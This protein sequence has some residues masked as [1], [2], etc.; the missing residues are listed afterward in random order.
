[1]IDSRRQQELQKLLERLGVERQTAINWQLLDQALIHPTFSST[2][3][4]DQLEFLGDS[5]L[6]LA[7]TLFLRQNFSNYAVGQLA[8]LRSHLVSD[9]VLAEIADGYGLDRFLMMKAFARRD[10][11][12]V[13]SRLADALEA[14]LAALYLSSNDLSLIT[15]WLN[16][17]LTQIST[18]LVADPTLGNYKAALQEFTQLHWKLLPEYRT[19]EQLEQTEPT[20][21]AEVWLLGQLWGQGQGLSIKAAQQSAAAVALQTLTAEVETLK[22]KTL[23]DQST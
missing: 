12:A 17:H 6:R 15:P 18:D 20:F 22:I 5:V 1:M 23:N 9:R 16:A 4:N 14:L 7:V 8:K 19:L 3:N 11:K 2:Y 21:T 13:Q 10:L